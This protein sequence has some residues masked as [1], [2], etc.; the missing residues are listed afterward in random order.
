MDVRCVTRLGAK[1]R[2]RGA[3]AALY[4]SRHAGGPYLKPRRLVGDDLLGAVANHKGRDAGAVAHVR[5]ALEDNLL[6][7]QRPVLVVALGRLQDAAAVVVDVA[8]L[9]RDGHALGGG[10]GGG[11][12]TA[13]GEGV[14]KKEEE[15]KKKKG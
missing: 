14:R 15:E 11:G 1:R 10:E 8:H 4:K 9:A 3:A 7:A 12:E 6:Q 2:Q 13:K 5:H